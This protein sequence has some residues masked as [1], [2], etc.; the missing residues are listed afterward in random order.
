MKYRYVKE[1]KHLIFLPWPKFYRCIECDSLHFDGWGKKG[2]VAVGYKKVR[3]PKLLFLP[4][5][6]AESLPKVV[7]GNSVL[8]V[9]KLSKTV[10]NENLL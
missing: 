1:P 8:K 9:P 2:F 10:K 3:R 7:V 5:V 6:Y 4:Q